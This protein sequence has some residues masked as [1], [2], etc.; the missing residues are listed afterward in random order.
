MIL[1][2]N[3]IH[4]LLSSCHT[5]TLVLIFRQDPSKHAT[6]TPNTALMYVCKRFNPE[7]NNTTV[8]Q[9]AYIECGS[10]TSY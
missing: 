5:S 4:R 1:S 2:H 7:I 8:C 3:V 9:G 6:E 10:Q